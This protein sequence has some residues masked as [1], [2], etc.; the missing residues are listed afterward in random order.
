MKKKL[1]FITSKNPRHFQQLGGGLKLSQMNIEL[2]ERAYAVEVEAVYPP[3]TTG[4]KKKFEIL[5][6]FGQ[7][8]KGETHFLTAKKRRSLVSKASASDVIFLDYSLYGA[9]AKDIKE[10]YPSKTVVTHFHNVESLF[11]DSAS[12]LPFPLNHLQAY[13]VRQAEKYACQ[14]S[15]LLFFLSNRDAQYFSAFK[16]KSQVCPPALT[17]QNQT[18]ARPRSPQDKL[19]ILFCGTYFKPNVH[20]ITWFA[21]NVLS[22]FNCTLNIVGLGM[23]KLKETLSHPRL[24]IVGPVKDLAPYYAKADIVISPIFTG[25]GM[26]M[27]SIEA[28]MYNKP[29]IG[30]TEAL[31][32]IPPSRYIKSADTKEQFLDALNLFKSSIEQGIAVETRSVY[33]NH[34]TP[35]RRASCF[36]LSIENA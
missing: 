30:T 35:E 17:D 7:L 20:G 9:V 22:D 25:S 2:L 1:L 5:R 31:I 11:A 36:A 14:Y 19:N 16:E 32:G 8:L 29:L 15:N 23:E 12:N 21:E 4:L 18:P 26:K 10:V 24:N 27:K 28:L 3:E 6:R 34:F 13:F 33:L